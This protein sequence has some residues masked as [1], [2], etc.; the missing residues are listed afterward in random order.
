MNNDSESYQVNQVSESPERNYNVLVSQYPQFSNQNDSSILGKSKPHKKIPN[1]NRRDEIKGV[2][3]ENTIHVQYKNRKM[4]SDVKAKSVKSK[5]RGEKMVDQKKRVSRE[6]S[7][8]MKMSVSEK[9]GIFWDQG[10][11]SPSFFVSASS[12]KVKWLHRHP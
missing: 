12:S 3:R 4:K 5:K 7:G 2:I 10:R 1:Y 9:R 11:S 6:E 8:K